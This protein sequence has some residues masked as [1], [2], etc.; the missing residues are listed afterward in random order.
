MEKICEQERHFYQQ[1][2]H[3]TIQD[4]LF[5]KTLPN[6]NIWIFHPEPGRKHPS[7]GASDGDDRAVLCT[8]Y[9][10]LEVLN[11]YSKICK[12]LL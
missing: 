6:N 5:I 11:E 7:I 3:Q 10:S 4:N 1:F 8:G 9:K 12:G 2:E